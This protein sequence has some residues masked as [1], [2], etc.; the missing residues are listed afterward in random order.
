MT[1]AKKFVGG[2]FVLLFGILVWYLF[3]KSYDYQVT[4]KVKTTPGT[5]NQSIK[6][7]ANALENATFKGQ[8]NEQH[9]MYQLQFNDSVHTYNWYLNA[10]N[11]STT[12]VQALIKDE[13][14]S[15]SNKITLPFSETNFEKRTLKT[16]KDAA[17]ALKEHLK[18]FKITLT[19]IDEIPAKYCAYMPFTTKQS[20]KALE[21]MKN[22]SYL[23]GVMA[24]NKF[25]LDGPP[26]IEVEHW[27][28][29]ND[30]I[31]FNFC[32]PII[33]PD[34]LPQIKGVFFKNIQK[35]KALKSIYNGNYITSDR[36][37][38]AM[39]R[40]AKKNNLQLLETPFE[41]FHNNPSMGGNELNWKA[42]VYLPLN[43]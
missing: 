27:N 3:I 31:R 19:G 12:Q 39:L 5:A 28:K 41:F 29:Q 7:W 43:D 40:Y 13:Q 21:M 9:L 18:R 33:K 35:R 8:K 4:F 26:F 32:Y 17:T 1:T 11:D 20:E 15:F 30:S 23:N 24:K 36:A 42:E 22:Y 16:V 2:I 10:L 6:L 37:W 14:H 34:S 25:K 38:Y